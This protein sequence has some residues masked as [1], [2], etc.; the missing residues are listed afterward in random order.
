MFRYLVFY[1]SRCWSHYKQVYSTGSIVTTYIENHVHTYV[2]TK[3]VNFY[4]PR[5]TTILLHV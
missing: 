3:N 4:H 2:T 1:F 5:Q